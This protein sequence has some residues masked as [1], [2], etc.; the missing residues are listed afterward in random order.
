[1][2]IAAYFLMLPSIFLGVIMGANDAGNILGPTIA[3]G[4]L[5]FK[6]AVYY[7]TAMILIGALV[8]GIPSLKVAS[9]LVKVD[10]AGIVIINTS[11]SLITLFFLR[12]ELPISMTQAIVGANVGV[13][14][15]LKEVNTKLLLYVVLGWFSTPVMSFVVAFI[16]F[17]FFALIFRGIRNLRIRDLALRLLLWFFTLYGAYSYGANNAGKVTGILVQSGFNKYLLLLFGGL[18]LSAG[19]FFFGK[20][21]IYTIGR[22]LVALDDFSAMISISASAMTIWLYS[23]VGLPIS[24]AHAIVGS[25]IGVGYARGTKIR[26]ARVVQRIFFSWLQAPLYSGI[27]SAFLFSIFK[28]LW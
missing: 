14:L 24:A 23:L 2:N 27:F 5:K 17:K 8:G 6:K 22:S 16:T 12:K 11:A 3:N 9:S 28:L 10:T 19:I 26:D 25:I 18:S 20:R 1:M 21:T 13:G 4:I 15:L 7:V